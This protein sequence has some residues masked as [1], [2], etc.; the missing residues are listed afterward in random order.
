MGHLDDATGNIVNAICSNADEL[1]FLRSTFI[2]TS[3]RN[4]TADFGRNP[5]FDF[6]QSFQNR[7]E[8]VVSTKRPHATCQRG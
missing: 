4:V 5:F 1:K 7:V 3:S 2:Q 6:L 8:F